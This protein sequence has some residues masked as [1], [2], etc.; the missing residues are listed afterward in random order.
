MNPAKLLAPIVALFIPTLA[1]AATPSTRPTE[2]IIVST[3][4]FITDLPGGYT[5]AHLRALLDKIS[6][7]LL[8]VEAAA[9]A[10]DPWTTAPYEL[11][12]VTRPYA[13]AHD[14]PILPAGQS[15]PS[16]AQDIGSMYQAL[17]SAGKAADFARL[18][19]TFQAALAEH[20]MTCAEMNSP[21]GLA[22]WRDYHTQLHALVGHDT[23][24]ERLN[25]QIV[26]N[27]LA[28]CRAHPHRRIAVLFG[29]AHA[30]YLTDHLA[31][32]PDLRVLPAEQFLPIT[33]ADLQS[34]TY[35]RDTVRS[36]RL[37]NYPPGSLTPDQL[38]TLES[39]LARLKASNQYPE[40][41]QY[42]TALLFLHERK[43]HQA[44]PLLESLSSLP[45]DA[46]LAFDATTPARDAARL[47]LARLAPLKSSASRP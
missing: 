41:L 4:H 35:D 17:Q 34:H 42:F 11:A 44:I 28:I 38:S 23:P 2:V 26:T 7:D 15:A 14:L 8:A 46:F 27:L 19:Q 33:D 32:R 36:L 25:A 18:E 37:L 31:A 13:I 29:G 5:P 12:A 1:A 39:H 16:Y 9:D 20:P 45:A 40:D 47:Q 24:W 3:Q 21:R 22:L 10:P 43:P 6:P 30:Y